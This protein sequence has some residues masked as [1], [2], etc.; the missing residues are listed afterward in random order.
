MYNFFIKVKNI[1]LNFIKRKPKKI[2]LPVSDIFI[3]NCEGE[4]LLRWD[5]VVKYLAIENYYGENDFGFELYLKMQSAR[6]WPARAIE[7]LKDFKDL[8]KSWEIN[9]YDKNSC[10]YVDTDLIL[11]NGAHRMALALYHNEPYINAYYIQRNKPADFSELWFCSN[12]FSEAE[13]SI[14]RKKS[15]DLFLNTCKNNTITSH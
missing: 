2:S 4:T 3:A 6:S 11:H 10:I 7:S 5:I 1:I 13:I 8:I 9:G 15:D 14:I 12:N